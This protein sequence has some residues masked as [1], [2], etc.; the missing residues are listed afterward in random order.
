MEKVFKQTLTITAVVGAVSTVFLMLS[1]LE[2]IPCKARQAIPGAEYE[3]SYC[4]GYLAGKLEYYTND[5]SIIVDYNLLLLYSILVI[6][7]ITIA[8]FFITLIALYMK[9]GKESKL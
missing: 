9:A 1:P 8:A 2:I 4:G 5:G 6:I 3:S 7:A